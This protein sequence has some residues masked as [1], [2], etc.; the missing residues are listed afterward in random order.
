M[1]PST[2]Y[3][4]RT[5][6]RPPLWDS[7]GRSSLSF[8][9][10][11]K[12]THV[13]AGY[14]CNDFAQGNTARLLDD[15]LPGTNASQRFVANA[16]LKAQA[17]A[18]VPPIAVHAPVSRCHIENDNALQAIYCGAVA[19]YPPAEPTRPPSKA[20]NTCPFAT[21]ENNGEFVPRER[22]ARIATTKRRTAPK[23]MTDTAVLRAQLGGVETG[24]AP[25]RQGRRTFQEGES[26]ATSNNGAQIFLPVAAQSD[27]PSRGRRP[28]MPLC[29]Q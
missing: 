18:G 19:K 15:R 1:F 14:Q 6:N 9:L 10:E 22:D 20:G 21:E 7:S 27:V 23:V 3:T 28:G 2:S 25:R 11:D 17:A 8:L 5:S 12:H 24:S 16:A 4:S 26:S 29:Y 13:P